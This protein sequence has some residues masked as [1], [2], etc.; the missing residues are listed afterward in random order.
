MFS[1]LRVRL[2]VIFLL[3]ASVPLIVTSLIVAQQSF[4]TLENEAIRVEQLVAGN[5]K[6]EIDTALRRSEN[7]LRF[8]V[9]IRGL[10]TLPQEEQK[11]LL[12]SLFSQRREYNELALLDADGQETIRFSRLTTVTEEDLTSR[13]DSPEYIEAMQTGN[14]YY[15]S[16]IFDEF[17]REPLL[18]IAVPVTDLRSGNITNVLVAEVRFRQIWDLIASFDIANESEVYVTDATGR[19]I[20]HRNP[21]IVLRSTQF[22]LPSQDGRTIGLDGDNVVMAMERVTLGDQTLIVIAERPLSK[23]LELA[24]DT[25]ILSTA[26]TIVALIVA[27]VLV[28][29][30]VRQIV[31][32]IEALSHVAEQIQA[33]DLTRQAEVRGRDEISVL[34]SAFNNMTNQL[35]QLIQNLENRVRERTRDLRIAG[36][37]SQQVTRLLDLKELLPTLVDLTRDG[38]NLSHVSVFLYDP[39]TEIIRLEA[40]SGEVGQA[41][42]QAGKQFHINDKGLVP[43]TIR[44]KEAQVINDVTQSADFL[45]NPLLPDTRSEAVFPMR[46]GAQLIGVLDMQSNQVDYFNTDY[47]NV[48]QSLADQIAV[49]VRN[50]ELFSEVQQAKEEAEQANIVKS[51]FLSAMSHELRTPLNA[52]L[53]FTQFVSSGMLGEV[54]QEQVDMLDKVVHSGK[55]LLSLINDV[56]DIS[57]IEAGALRLFVEEDINLVTELDAIKATAISLLEEK[58]VEL[59]TDVETDLPLVVGDRRRLRQVMLNLTSN[60]CKFTE[61]GHIKITLKQEADL[62]HFS[63]SDTGAGIAPEDHGVIFET[64]RQTDVGLKQ[65]EGTGLGLPI[66]KRLVEI[67]G[68]NLWFE[69]ELGKGSTFHF[70]I[71]I[72]NTQLV[73]TKGKSHAV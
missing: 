68:G 6:T 44:L 28:L 43:L 72:H 40:S 15:S 45:V 25:L 10:G 27:G 64:F 26:V 16:V 14:I 58:P 35:R 29:I 13:A 73:V 63:I 33:G 46:I 50:A 9:D 4:S 67:H 12:Q 65:G 41:M 34:A 5:V 42:L 48:L 1:S 61:E 53:N 54:N 21:S 37:V 23:A 62:I 20:A 7:E 30:V 18:T 66:S 32:P 51:Q 55:H 8:L 56:L 69:S 57:K 11:L 70:T 2:T 49:A 3:L 52:I 71:P 47:V 24:T 19:V 17:I 60:A 36:E 22:D 38:F 39:Q 59:I 31:R